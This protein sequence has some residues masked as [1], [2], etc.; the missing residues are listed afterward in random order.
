[1]KSDRM[2][3]DNSNVLLV[4]S[5]GAAVWW[6]LFGLPGLN[7]LFTDPPRNKQIILM[8]TM[9]FGSFCGWGFYLCLTPLILKTLRMKV[10]R[11]PLQTPAIAIWI[12]A[13][14]VPIC[15]STYV[16]ID[17]VSNIN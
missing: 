14:L 10:G 3:I 15:I 6:L 7:D 9:L 17:H 8:V 11:R 16:L 2:K 4:G 5:V 13:P 12:F 1:M